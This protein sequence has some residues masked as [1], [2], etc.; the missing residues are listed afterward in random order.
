[1]RVVL[2]VLCLIT[3]F[4]IAGTSAIYAYRRDWPRLRR[5]LFAHYRGLS[6]A[7]AILWVVLV[8]GVLIRLFI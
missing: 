6:G 8:V 5:F 1:M 7:P 3:L 4:W 2:A